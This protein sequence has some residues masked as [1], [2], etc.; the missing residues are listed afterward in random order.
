MF[1][2]K[3][4]SARAFTQLLGKCC[5]FTSNEQLHDSVC[6]FPNKILR[7]CPFLWGNVD[8]GNWPRHQTMITKQ[9][10]DNIRSHQCIQALDQIFADSTAQAPSC[11][12]H[13]TN[14]QINCDC[15]LPR[16]MF[17]LLELERFYTHLYALECMALLLITHR[18]KD[19]AKLADYFSGFEFKQI[20]H[21]WVQW[22]KMKSLCSSGLA[23]NVAKSIYHIHI[24]FIY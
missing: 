20:T 2:G 16:A 5:N 21:S 9:H 7:T 12:E 6:S 17:M 11:T 24:L 18:N 15:F 13:T 4:C 22:G 1:I 3:H 14:S 23:I 8:R 19:L 10:M